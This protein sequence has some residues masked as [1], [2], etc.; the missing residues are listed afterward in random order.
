MVKTQNYIISIGKEQLAALPVMNYPAAITVVESAA[1]AHAA[2]RE[3]G[4]AHV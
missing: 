1:V 3:I 2:L 4:R